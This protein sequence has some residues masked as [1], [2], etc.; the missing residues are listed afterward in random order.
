[1]TTA[2]GH[3]RALLALLVLST[4]CTG[5]SPTAPAPDVSN[6]TPAPA[7]PAVTRPAQVYVDANSSPAPSRYLLYDDGTFALQ[8]SRLGLEYR[9]TYRVANGVVTFEWEGG[10]AAGPWGATGSLN[11]DALS[12]RYNLIMQLSDFED[13]VYLRTEG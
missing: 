8:Y 2:A 9:G 3:C 4:A 11:G 1:M 13:G 7:F 10:S 12:V 5:G 6:R